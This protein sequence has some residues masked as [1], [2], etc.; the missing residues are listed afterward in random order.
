[1]AEC[2]NRLEYL[3]ELAGERARWP[4]HDSILRQIVASRER[5]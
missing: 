5:G 4:T 2:T 1:L 3:L